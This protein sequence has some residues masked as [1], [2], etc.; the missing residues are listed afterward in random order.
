MPARSSPFPSRNSPAHHRTLRRR[1]SRLSASRAPP[2]RTP[3]GSES[4]REFPSPAPTQFHSAH[5]RPSARDRLLWNLSRVR[6]LRKQTKRTTQLGPLPSVFSWFLTT[7]LK[8]TGI[9]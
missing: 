5:R 8:F 7:Q 6:R 9:L 2:R 3:N 1:R 4:P